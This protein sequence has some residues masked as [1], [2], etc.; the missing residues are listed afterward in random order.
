M[1]VG[2]GQFLFSGIWWNL[3]LKWFGMVSVFIL[4]SWNGLLIQVRTINPCNFLIDMVLQSYSCK[5][6]AM[7]WHVHI[8]APSTKHHKS[9]AAL[10][11]FTAKCAASTF[12]YDQMSDCFVLLHFVAPLGV[13][14]R[15]SFNFFTWLYN[16]FTGGPHEEKSLQNEI[17]S[18][19]LAGDWHGSSP[20]NNEIVILIRWESTFPTTWP[21]VSGIDHSGIWLSF[22]R[23]VLWSTLWDLQENTTKTEALT[24]I[25]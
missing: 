25:A 21:V 19:T 17:I 3:K 16:L 22:A 18:K 13:F 5:I 12:G 15:A 2:S 1:H 4:D 11:R 8:Q 6:L 7:V 20:V 24:S 9:F 23:L 14:F 10:S